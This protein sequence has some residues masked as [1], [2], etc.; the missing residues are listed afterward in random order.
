VQWW[1]GD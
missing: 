1:S